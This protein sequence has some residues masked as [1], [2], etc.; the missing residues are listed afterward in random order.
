MTEF[1]HV[2]SYNGSRKPFQVIVNFQD[3]YRSRGRV[4]VSQEART[5]N[6]NVIVLAQ[7]KQEGVVTEQTSEGGDLLTLVPAAPP[8]MCKRIVHRPTPLVT[9]FSFVNHCPEQGS[10]ISSLTSNYSDSFAPTSNSIASA[11]KFMLRCTGFTGVSN[12]FQPD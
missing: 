4:L 9:Q 1:I 3:T 5:R 12:A 8:R 11:T 2:M 6:C 10:N 7:R